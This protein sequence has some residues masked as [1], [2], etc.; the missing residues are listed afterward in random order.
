MDAVSTGKCL[1]G[2]VAFTVTGE[3]VAMGY[4]HCSSCR[5]WL[6]SPVYLFTMWP[7]DAVTVT[8]GA[9][10]VTT[11]LTTPETVSHRQFCLTCG[12][13][14]MIRHPSM[15]LIDV[16]A[17]NLP[18]LDFLP[19]MHVNYAETVFR[20]RDGLPKLAGFPADFG[21]SGEVVPE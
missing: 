21:G 17:M 14:V 20:M 3:P 2:A 5:A 9:A 8:A 15:G 1:C 19:T 4:C 12:S 10:N 11:Y 6:A 16:P 7:E 18:G 13:G